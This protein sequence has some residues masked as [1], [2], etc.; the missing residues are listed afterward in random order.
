MEQPSLDHT[1]SSPS[2]AAPH[3]AAAAQD[4]APISRGMSAQGNEFTAGIGA[5]TTNLF[6]CMLTNAAAEARSDKSLAH[7]LS[8]LEL[9]SPPRQS[10]AA[11]CSHASAA[12]SASGPE[13][14]VLAHASGDASYSSS[15]SSSSSLDI[16]SSLII[17]PASSP[18]ALAITGYCQT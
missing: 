9:P 8:D 14:S 3:A 11:Q 1:L 7:L 10:A 15:S 18:N 6:V 13:T 17:C 16:P 5:F 2:I 4:A 12:A